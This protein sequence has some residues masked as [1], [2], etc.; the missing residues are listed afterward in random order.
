MRQIGHGTFGSVYSGK[1]KDGKVVAVKKVL[2]DVNY[3]VNE[4]LTIESWM[5]NNADGK[6]P[7]YC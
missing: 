3:K 7:I 1:L 5:S 2:Q 6:P 4:N